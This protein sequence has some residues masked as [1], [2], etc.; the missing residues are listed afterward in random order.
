MRSEELERSIGTRRCF[1]PLPFQ[2]R[3]RTRN[4]PLQPFFLTTIIRACSLRAIL[5]LLTSEGGSPLRFLVQCRKKQLR[6]RKRRKTKPMLFSC[7]FSLVSAS[8]SGSLALSLVRFIRSKRRALSL[9][10]VLSRTMPAALLAQQRA[11]SGLSASISG[12]DQES[13]R[14][15][16]GPRKSTQTPPSSTARFEPARSSRRIDSTVAQSSSTGSSAGTSG[17]GFRRA[18][19]QNAAP[20]SIRQTTRPTTT[21]PLLLLPLL[22]PPLPISTKE[23]SAESLAPRRRRPRPPNPWSRQ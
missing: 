19:K 6:L 16:P 4:Q 7:F 15:R 5:R 1:L 22:R 8:S 14:R 9:A 23:P 21:L 11:S 2:S 20:I 17:K 12:E 10:L 3:I 18:A 13:R